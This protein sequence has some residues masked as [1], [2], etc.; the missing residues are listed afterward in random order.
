MAKQ[1]SK[2]VEVKVE[3]F[4]KTQANRDRRLAKHLK[5]HPND[6]QA[7]SAPKE[8]PRR[9]K[10]VSKGSVVVAPT[11]TLSGTDKQDLRE[12]MKATQGKFGVIR[13]NIFGCEYS[14]ENVRAYC[15]GVGIRFTGNANKPRSQKRKAK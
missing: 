11:L 15:F 12:I 7:A 9:R 3:S 2:K 8:A 6:T 5:A 1:N 14:R 10:P 13:P 4:P